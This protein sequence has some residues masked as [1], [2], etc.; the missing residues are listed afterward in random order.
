M[1]EYRKKPVQIE[2]H[3]VTVF[4]LEWMAEWCGGTV[5]RATADA[6]HRLIAIRTLEGLMEASVGDWIIRGI[7]GEFYPCKHEIFEATYELADG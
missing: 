4:N 2:A 7:A 3:R 1:P 6:K 5:T